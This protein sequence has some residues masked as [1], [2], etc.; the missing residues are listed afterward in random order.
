MLKP[1]ISVIAC[2]LFLMGADTVLAK[3]KGKKKAPQWYVKTTL[4]VLDPSTGR[5]VHD[6]RSGVFGQLDASD[7]GYDT[8]D[9]PAFANVASSRAAIVFEQ[10]ED[11]GDRAGQYLSDY[12]PTG[13]NND[14][15]TFSVFST[16]N[17]SEVTLNWDGLFLVEQDSNGIFRENRDAGNKLLN[18]LKL[19][20]LTTGEVVKATRRE[21]GEIVMRSHTFS[22]DG[23]TQ[24]TFRWVLGDVTDEHLAVSTSTTKSKAPVS[25]LQARQA[26]ALLSVPSAGRFGTPPEGGD[27]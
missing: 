21:R 22:M 25:A 14:H 3:K 4:S 26:E 11:W 17:S 27:Q 10:G 2:T 18:K 24:R 9:T 5:M 20:D 19:V 13:I 7:L 23:Q 12:H 16:T 1:I 6:T 8:Y 15:W